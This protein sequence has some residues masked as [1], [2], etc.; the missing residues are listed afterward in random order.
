[1]PD[2]EKTTNQSNN[3]F[4]LRFKKINL[5][6]K[7]ITSKIYDYE[8]L[9]F[10]LFLIYLIFSLFIGLLFH[11]VGNYG[12]E[13]D[14]F[15][16]Y[17]P[18]AKE[19]HN[20]HFPIDD[21]RGPLYPIV[22]AFFNILIRDY[23]TSGI[24][25]SSLSAAIAIFIS[26]KL[27]KNI[28]NNTFAFYSVLLI[29]SNPFFIQHSYLCGTDM[30][31]F[32]LTT[33]SIYKFISCKNINSKS[34]IISAVFAGLAYLTR[35]IGVFLLGISFFIF[36]SKALETPIKLKLRFSLL[37]FF[38]FGVTILPWSLYTYF[39]KGSFFYNANYKNVLYEMYG[40]NWEKF[41]FNQTSEIN[42]IYKVIF[43]SPLQFILTLLKNIVFHFWSDVHSLMGIHVGLFVIVGII[44]LFLLRKSFKTSW[45]LSAFL[46]LGLIYFFILAMIFY[47][48]RFS[49][50]LLPIYAFLAV[51]G[52]RYLRQKLNKYLLKPIITLIALLIILLN[53]VY[54]FSFNS[55]NINS[56]PVE[57]LSLK[58]WFN[59]NIP[60]DKKG[61][62]ICARKPHIAYYLELNFVPLPVV[63]N[64]SD[65]IKYLREKKVDY[66]YFGIYEA[67]TRDTFYFLLDPQ[68]NH[69]NLQTVVYS[70]YPK[71]V[72]YRVIK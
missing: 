49:L 56:G 48:E 29:I 63:S 46:I 59:K 23:F 62:S 41:W 18:Q 42:S 4:L 43:L 30:L 37:Y 16:S 26:H 61:S 33:T 72:L 6:L 21:F 60:Q 11:K 50:P 52:L 3:K 55:S 40:T 35:Y 58:E 64:Y 24:I 36:F 5:F 27:L 32:V 15:W 68:I 45:K 31:F 51:T 20:L 7:V 12:V 47:S 9:S 22:L 1:M 65:L 8:Y 2:E 17:V 25:I 70:D 39:K 10:V 44:G 34:I 38:S 14:F 69:P 28:T 19:F 57:L 67:Y 53:V 71:S 54:S 66:L 13:T